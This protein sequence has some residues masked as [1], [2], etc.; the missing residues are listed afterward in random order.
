MSN[1]TQRFH[2]DE[3]VVSILSGLIANA[4]MMLYDAES[5]L[6]GTLEDETIEVDYADACHN[7]R[8]LLYSA[9]TRAQ[10]IDSFRADIKSLTRSTRQTS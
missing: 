5:S 4:E 2:K 10:D 1:T 6:K 8:A 9:R 7:Y 3:T